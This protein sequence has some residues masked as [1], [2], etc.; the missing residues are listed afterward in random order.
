LILKFLFINKIKRLK[1]KKLLLFTLLVILKN[2]FVNA[3]TYYVD[4]INGRD[5]YSGTNTGLAWQTIEKVDTVS[6]SDPSKGIL[7]PGDQIL[8]KRG[9]TWT[10]SNVSLL[11]KRSGSEGAP[12]IYGAY[13]ESDTKPVIDGNNIV[14]YCINVDGQIG[15]SKLSYLH[16]IQIQDLKFI[17]G[18]DF[19]VRIW[20]CTF[21][22]VFN[23]EMDN[24]YGNL[25]P[26]GY[27]ANIYIGQG[28]NVNVDHC[29]ITNTALRNNGLSGEC[30]YL[31]GVDN[32]ILENTLIDVG[33]SGIRIGF[34]SIDQN[35]PGHTDNLTVRYCTVKNQ[36]YDCIDD[37]GAVSSLFY[38]NVFESSIAHDHVILYIFSPSDYSL[39]VPNGNSYFNNTFIN[40]V[41]NYDGGNSIEINT[42]NSTAN[43]LI[44]KNNL[45]YTD[46]IGD[47]N[48]GYTFFNW[49][50][51]GTWNFDNNIYYVATGAYNHTWLP[52]YSFD[53]VPLPSF[54]AWQGYGSHNYDAHSSCQDPLFSGNYTLQSSSPATLSGTW[55]GLNAPYNH[56]IDG[57][58]IGNPPD[59][60]AYQKSI[61]KAGQIS[62][63]T[64]YS[65]SIGII[66]DLALAHGHTLTISP[67]THFK[68]RNDANIELHGILSSQYNSQMGDITFSPLE[69]YGHWGSMIFD[70]E[71]FSTSTL[72]HSTLTNSTGIQCLN[73]AN[74]NIEYS[75]IDSSIQGIYVY[76][77]QA[78][79]SNNFITNSAS[80]G[81]FGEATA[82]NV[83][84]AG[85]TI[86]RT[87]DPYAEV[88]GI[89]FT[90][91]SSIQ[92]S[93]NY[94]SGFYWGALLGDE[95]FM[96]TGLNYDATCNNIIT[97]NVYGIGT[98]GACTT[99]AGG[100]SGNDLVGDRNSIYG[101]SNY[102][103]YTTDYSYVYAVG[104]YLGGYYPNLY[105]DNTSTNDIPFYFL[106]DPCAT[107]K[108]I[109]NGNVIANS[110]LKKSGEENLLEGLFLEKEN[111]IDEAIDFYKGLISSDSHVNF[112]I[113]RL[114]VIRSNYSRPELIAYIE[115]LLNT[116]N[117]YYSKIKNLLGSIYFQENRFEDG[118]TA[119]NNVID[120]RTEVYDGINARFG[121]LF[122][123]L[124]IRNDIQ[125]ASEILKEIKSIDPLDRN[126]LIKIKAA[127]RLLEN[128]NR[129]NK[130]LASTNGNIPKEY[131]LSQNYPNPFNPST[132]IR[133][134]IPKSG[135]VTLKVYD[136]L[137]KEVAT[138]VNENKA[139]GS[140]DFT[141]NASRFASG[142]YIYQLRVNDFV[143]SKKMIMLK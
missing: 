81:I 16:Y 93:S 64:T 25:S 58:P 135:I 65:G 48:T 79:I 67:A 35:W 97:G 89:Y 39:Y 100:Y 126:T 31:D 125:S 119:F 38:Y 28:S 106:T 115:S 73:G 41:R 83:N 8:F 42:P 56:D 123:Y 96:V 138:L 47:D 3:T 142:V 15:T 116:S 18:G 86:T 77:A 103:L 110:S 10:L 76:N 72:Q 71:S 122:G 74:V 80:Y 33:R 11:P 4:C 70:E 49:A 14:A 105:A 102:E 82:Q 5:Y 69:K 107:S 133:Y 132:T 51:P 75:T 52:D 34:G 23:C 127:E 2:P 66:G 19:N 88:E 12:I 130:N 6:D 120:R 13:G 118:I 26:N 141:F 111:R 32:A 37:D 84:I 7:N 24:N 22:T 59:L 85:N 27:S 140:Y 43:N 90:D 29:T 1:M 139:E 87:F 50:H 91:N 44:F 40:H 9:C 36:S 21:V 124:N 101:N 129:M 131:G 114:A 78:N 94:I 60:G 136:I 20:D 55:V 113:T 30:I 134:Q 121:K 63:D 117:K 109:D 92:M 54:A 137:G 61:Y 99:I 104:D 46:N 45:F 112:A 53:T 68:I 98:C 143:S 62:V 128:S 17:H 57:T 108:K 95:T